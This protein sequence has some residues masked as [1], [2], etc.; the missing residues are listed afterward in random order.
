MSDLIVR[1]VTID[2]VRPHPNADKLE[3]VKVGGWQIVSGKGNYQAGQTAIHVPPDV[4]VPK[5]MADLWAVT[6]YLS[7]KKDATKGRVKAVKL[8]GA[9]SFGF[10]APNDTNAEVGTNLAEALG[11]EKYEEPVPI[12]MQAGQMAKNHPLFHMYTDI[13]NLRNFPDMLNYGNPLIVTEKLHG[14]NSRIGWVRSMSDNPCVNQDAEL[15]LE[16]VVG[17]HRTQRKVEDPGVY[18]LPFD[19]YGESLE[20]AKDE[21]V[22]AMERNLIYSEEGGIKV[23][24]LIFFGEI[25]GPGVQ[26]LTYGK[27]KAWR[28]FDIAVNGTYL[29]FEY[30]RSICNQFALPIV[31]HMVPGVY[32]FEELCGLAEGDSVLSPGQIKEGIVV[33]PL[34]EETWGKGD[35]DPH[36]K[37]SIF[38]V[39]SPDYLTRKGGTE[40]H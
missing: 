35:L 40:H 39:I 25:Y 18:G 11:I 24:S 8:R 7:W 13:Q 26:D 17:T 12:G 29:P 9:P 23:Q 37:R 19:L 34:G 1:V 27:E 28:I 3:I 33:R 36:P 22:S 21:I 6:P 10:L 31:P 5:A 32:T 2:E 15:S 16:K 30:V 14:T 20:R 4:M 38:K